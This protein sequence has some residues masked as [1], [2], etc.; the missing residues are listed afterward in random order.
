[1]LGDHFQ[2]RLAVEIGV[3]QVALERIACKPQVLHHHRVVQAKLLSNGF[4]LLFGDGHPHHFLKRVP[5]AI[6]NGKGN[7]A[8]H[9][10]DQKR[11]GNPLN[12]KR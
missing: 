7:H 2:G 10:H 4:P 9:K 12:Q 3:A 6:L 11:L 8:D 5:E 1:M